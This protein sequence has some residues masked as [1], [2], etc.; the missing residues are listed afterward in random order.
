MNGWVARESNGDLYLYDREPYAVYYNADT[1]S[2]GMNPRSEFSHWESLGGRL[3]LHPNTH[4]YV[5][6]KQKRECRI[7]VKLKQEKW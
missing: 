7:D 4:K 5:K 2:G 1:S 6:P 3:K